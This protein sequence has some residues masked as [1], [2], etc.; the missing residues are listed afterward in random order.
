MLVVTWMTELNGGVNGFEVSYS[1]VGSFCNGVV[2]GRKVVESGMMTYVLNDL[3]AYTEYSV[4][5]R[6]RGADGF[7]QPSAA[8]MKRTQAGSKLKGN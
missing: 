2:G 6:A 8:M 4:T 1:P 7:G 3:Q 5:V